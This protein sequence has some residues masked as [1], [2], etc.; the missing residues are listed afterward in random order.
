M[1]VRQPTNGAVYY[2]NICWFNNLLYQ[3]VGGFQWS[4]ASTNTGIGNFQ[5]DYNLYTNFYRNNGSLPGFGGNQVS[6]AQ[7]QQLFPLTEQHSVTAPVSF[8]NYQNG[9]FRLASGSGGV[10]Q[11]T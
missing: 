3:S 5:G 4:G 1:E 6:L 11:G 9:D 7:F 2:T 10:G 8:M